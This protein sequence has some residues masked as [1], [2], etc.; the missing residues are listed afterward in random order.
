MAFQFLTKAVDF[1]AAAFAIKRTSVILHPM[2]MQAAHLSIAR[3][4]HNEIVGDHK[5]MIG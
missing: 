2:L 5:V 1:L 4:F 3:Q